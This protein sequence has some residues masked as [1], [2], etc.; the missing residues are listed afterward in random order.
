MKSLRFKSVFLSGVAVV[1]SVLLMCCAHA[2]SLVGSWR[3]NGRTATMEFL[4]DGSFNAVDNEGM[5]VS[6]T[7][8]TLE[9]GRVRF[10]IRHPGSS[11]EIVILEVSVAGDELAITSER[12][13]ETERYR[14]LKQ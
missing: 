8:V 6:G 12:P 5:A 2:P 4:K 1:G 9:N 13:G 7:Y 3:E 10:E 11:P 14:R